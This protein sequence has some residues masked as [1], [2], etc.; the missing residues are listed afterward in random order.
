[1]TTEA[2]LPGQA[3]PKRK[4]PRR[5]LE[6]RGK[7]KELCLAG[8]TPIQIS[9]IIGKTK[10]AVFL[11]LKNL[12]ADGELRQDQTNYQ[13][14]GPLEERKWYKIVERMIEELP[15]YTR[16]GIVPTARKMGYRLIELGVMTKGD[17][18]LF[19]KK[20]AEARRGVDYTYTKPSNLPKAPI[21]CFVDEIRQTTGNTDIDNKPWEPTPDQE[22]DDPFQ[23]AEDAIK[24]CK[25][26]ILEYDGRCYEGEKGAMPGR[27]Y[28]Q[29][30]YC[31]VW[32][33]SDAISVDLLRFLHGKNVKV[34][35]M[36][37]Q[38]STP[39]MVECCRRLE[40]IAN[41][42][43]HIE[44]IAILYF[45]DSDDA[46]NNIRNKV[47]AALRFYSGRSDDINIPVEVELRHVMITPEQVR[48]YRLTGYQL[49]AFMT[50]EKRLRDFKKIA[51]E[52]VDECWDKDIY[53]D[54]C[55]PEK[56]DYEAHGEDEPQDIDPD[57]LCGEVY[58]DMSEEDDEITI[59]EKMVQMATEAFK[60]G[61]EKERQ[62]EKDD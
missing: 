56:Y 23:V 15:F 53:D 14:A 43:D 47:E 49:E 25:D 51:I 7:I 33:E 61:W 27:W 4:S 1:L 59:R 55:P 21:D 35:A 5:A 19:Y 2:C 58:S 42:H 54:N 20:S 6:L 10:Q 32:G 40:R 45:G 38:F 26:A 31:E 50:T 17:F 9:K 41:L 16:Q 52:A 11:H 37:G 57:D 22:P 28:K 60:P 13:R 62:N 46:G 39:F 8:H 36:R 12:V 44:K 29:P 3:K 18:D 24:Q 30:I 48:K 34:A